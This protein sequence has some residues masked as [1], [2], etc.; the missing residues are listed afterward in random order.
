MVLIAVLLWLVIC[1][2]VVFWLNSWLSVLLF[3]TAVVAYGYYYYVAIKD[4]GGT[5]GD[6]AGFFVQVCE[7]MFVYAL[8][9]GGKWL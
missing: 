2:V 1:D 9:L 5:T 8:M 3:L 7:L 6:I 4:F